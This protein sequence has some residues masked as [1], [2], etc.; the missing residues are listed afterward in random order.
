LW[1]KDLE[2]NKIQKNY[3]KKLEKKIRKNVKQPPETVARRRGGG[4][5]AVACR[6]SPPPRHRS[7]EAHRGRPPPR[8]SR[9]PTGDS[10]P[11]EPVSRPP[12]LPPAAEQGSG[13]QSSSLRARC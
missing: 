9:S 1:R 3:R 5:Y 12:P 6:G 2:R 8:S 7:P 4:L 13:S 11:Q 10:S